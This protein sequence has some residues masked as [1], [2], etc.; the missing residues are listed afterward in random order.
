MIYMLTHPFKI[1]LYRLLPTNRDK[2]Q[3]LFDKHFGSTGIS[4]KKNYTYFKQF[5]IIS[6][7]LT[8]YQQ[9][10]DFCRK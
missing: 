6:S 10:G 4:L 3:F 7:K 9:N 8:F 2:S 5:F 1:E